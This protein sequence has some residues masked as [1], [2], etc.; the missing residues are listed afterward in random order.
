MILDFPLYFAFG[1]LDAVSHSSGQQQ[2]FVLRAPFVRG[3]TRK[4]EFESLLRIPH[5]IPCCLAK[6]REGG[7]VGRPA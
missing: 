4:L 7:V 6:Q 2:R 5:V 3:R 1:S